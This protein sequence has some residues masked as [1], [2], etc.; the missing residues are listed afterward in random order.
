MIG[1]GGEFTIGSFFLLVA[2]IVFWIYQ[3]RSVLTKSKLVLNDWVNKHGYA[4]IERKSN[5]TFRIPGTNYELW[6]DIYNK[7]LSFQVVLKNNAGN[8][9]SGII[10]VNHKTNEVKEEWT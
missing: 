6:Y 5:G 10:S 1:Y 7:V 2:I 8:Q 9:K 4:I 3:S